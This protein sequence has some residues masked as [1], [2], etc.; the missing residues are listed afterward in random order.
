MCLPAWSAGDCKAEL[1]NVA[2][3]TYS[4]VAKPPGG[5]RMS[6]TFASS[7]DITGTL[8]LDTPQSITVSRVAQR[9]VYT[10]SGMTGD[11]VA[12]ELYGVTTTP[13]GQNIKFTVYKPDGTTLQSVTLS[14]NTA[15]GFA[16]L[17]SLPASGPYKV[18][19]YSDQG[20]PWS[21]QLVVTA[22]SATTIDGSPA[23]LATSSASQ[24]LRYTFTGTAGQRLDLG[25]F[26]LTYAT[27]SSSTTAFTIYTPDGT[28]L[29]SGTCATSNAGSCDYSSASLPATGNYSVMFGPP[30]TS[31][32]TAGSFALST[33]LSGTFVIAD[34]AQTISI[35]RAGQTARYTFNGTA[36]QTLHLNWSSVSI[37]GTGS[38]A[39][40]VLKP[41]G[42]TLS[43]SSF[44][45]G[46]NGGMAI[47]ALPTS[48]AYT[49][50]FDPPSGT[51]MSG[52]FA[53][54]TP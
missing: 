14:P 13:A 6:G 31:S 21:G 51:T 37:A 17:Q 40:S 42:T 19:V 8:T 34:P 54:V 16:N 53:L 28:V 25:V 47:S 35:A 11:S 45:N 48:G 39:V 2:A 5:A 27:S 10:F 44:L 22:G 52:S 24:P 30:A 33:P 7:A 4:V 3:G 36:S 38:V 43:S 32:I 26:G 29:G 18:I 1:S 15:A 23:T 12:V 41:D 46:A 49:V 20:T 50:V 9:A